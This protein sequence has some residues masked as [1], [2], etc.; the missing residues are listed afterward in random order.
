MHNHAPGTKHHFPVG[1]PTLFL[2]MA[3]QKRA[4]LLTGYYTCQVIPLSE[5]VG[6]CMLCWYIFSILSLEKINMNQHATQM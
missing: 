3:M 6:L 2:Q 1:Q 5:I 4:G